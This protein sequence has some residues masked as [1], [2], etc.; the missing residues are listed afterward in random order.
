MHGAREAGR[1]VTS[2]KLYRGTKEERGRVRRYEEEED[3]EQVFF[4]ADAD[5]KYRSVG[6]L[7]GCESIGSIVWATDRRRTDRVRKL[8]VVYVSSSHLPNALFQK[9]VIDKATKKMMIEREKMADLC[10]EGFYINLPC[11]IVVA[12]CL[13]F[14]SL[15][16]NSSTDSKIK[17]QSLPKY[18]KQL[19]LL[20]FSIFAVS[21]TQVLLALNWGGTKSAWNSATV[22]GLFCGSGG[23]LIA[24]II[25]EG[26]MGRE[27]MIPFALVK[28]QVVWSSCINYGCFAGCLLTSSYYLP[29]YFQAVRNASPTMSGVDLLP[30]I[31]G[32]MIF[33]IITGSLGIT[34]SKFFH[35]P[36][37]WFS[38]PLNISHC[39]YA[40][41]LGLADQ[42][43]T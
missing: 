36:S 43:S 23:A 31:L 28:R 25:W 41:L 19:D 27:A 9:N 35:S 13:L 42:D 22:I 33:A 38:N 18:L 30:S 29:I 34:L 16:E 17:Q 3:G 15:P 4:S 39:I 21:S 32:N 40:S 14:I 5:E 6:Y 12:L 11:G 10:G 8:A 24:F 37:L 2:R 1:Y 26:W 7:D 20:G